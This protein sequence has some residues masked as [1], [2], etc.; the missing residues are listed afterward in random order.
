MV[1]DDKKEASS[2]SDKKLPEFPKD[3]LNDESLQAELAEQKKYFDDLEEYLL[4]LYFTF[5]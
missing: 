2:P 3:K 1:N 5:R 4:Y